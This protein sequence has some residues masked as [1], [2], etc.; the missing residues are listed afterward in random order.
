MSFTTERIGF[1]P[2][3]MEEN[4]GNEIALEKIREIFG[5]SFVE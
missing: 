4:L 3:I 5:D 1:A 2:V